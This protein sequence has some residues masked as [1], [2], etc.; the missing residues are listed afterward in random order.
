M[1]GIWAYIGNIARLQANTAKQCTETL[2]PRGPESINTAVFANGS[3]HL[4]FTRLAI[5][6]LHPSGMQPMTYGRIHWICNGEIYNWKELRDF[7]YI[8]SY[9]S[10][11]FLVYFIENENLNALKITPSRLLACCVSDVVK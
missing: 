5:N 10:T 11:E 3:A 2:L 9:N 8:G 1:C 4:G 7:E 6:G